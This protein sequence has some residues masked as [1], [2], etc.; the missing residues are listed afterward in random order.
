M[1]T[2]DIVQPLIASLLK[3]TFDLL[4]HGYPQKFHFRFHTHTHTY[5]HTYIQAPIADLVRSKYHK[6]LQ[7]VVVSFWISLSYQIYDPRVYP[8]SFRWKFYREKCPSSTFSSLSLSLPSSHSCFF[9]DSLFT[10]LPILSFFVHT[11]QFHFETRRQKSFDFSTILPENG[12]FFFFAVIQG[13]GSRVPR[14]DIYIYICI[15][16]SWTY[17]IFLTFIIR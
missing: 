13:Q 11:L 4:S 16:S 6:L 2:T 5:I 14:K 15:S 12:N 1:R 10:L 3:S 9:P 8:S 7:P 17:G